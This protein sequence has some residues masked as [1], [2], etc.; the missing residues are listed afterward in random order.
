MSTESSSDTSTSTIKNVVGGDQ[1]DQ[2]DQEFTEEFDNYLRSQHCAGCS[3]E[4]DIPALI[5]AKSC[6]GL[7]I[8][9]YHNDKSENLNAVF[10]SK[11]CLEGFDDFG[12][13]HC[14]MCDGPRETPK[15]DMKIKFQKLGG[16][17]SI[18]ALCS[19]K[20]FTALKS[21][22][23]NDSAMELKVA[24]W[25]CDKLHEKKMPF[26]GRCKVATYCD[27]VCQKRHWPT[28]KHNCEPDAKPKD[29]EHNS[30]KIKFE[31]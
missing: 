30:T 17:V 10:C 27:R 2:N 4:M 20:C 1:N 22:T 28:H 11:E 29:F 31:K 23:M 18:R 12:P 14:V 15:W 3:I 21:S 9:N 26:C 8:I 25:Y 13:I 24:C 16:W 5:D 6:E 19:E 7:I